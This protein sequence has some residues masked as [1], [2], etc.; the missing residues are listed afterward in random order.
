MTLAKGIKARPKVRITPL[1]KRPS[2]IPEVS[3]IVAE[4]RSVN[5]A[6]LGLQLC[7]MWLHIP[8]TQPATAFDKMISLGIM[9]MLL[10]GL[11]L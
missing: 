6:A 3:Q 7:R 4:R 11:L 8:D 10:Q 2:M 9:H 5:Q 1:S